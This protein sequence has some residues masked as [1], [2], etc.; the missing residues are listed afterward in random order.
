MYNSVD[1]FFLQWMYPFERYMKILK[2]YVRNRYRSEACIIENYIVEEVVEFYNEYLHNIYPIG[3]PIDHI[4][5]DK[6]GRGITLG[7]SHVVDI[8]MLRQ[9]HLYVLYNLVVVDSYIEEHKEQLRSENPLNTRNQIWIQNKHIKEFIE[10]F[11]CRIST[12]LCETES[13]NIDKSLKY[14]AFLPNHC[15]VKYD[16]Y[17]IN[18]YRFFTKNAALPGP[19]SRMRNAEG[20]VRQSTASVKLVESIMT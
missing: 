17:I 6:Y 12:L 4:A 14:L 1:L 10:W 7:K 9:T 19:K 20:C 5:V 13:A 11:G 15:V 2:G 8:N 16:R 18:G 3:I